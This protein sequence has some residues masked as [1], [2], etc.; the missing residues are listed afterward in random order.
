MPTPVLLS[1][2]VPP[3]QFNKLALI[4]TSGLDPVLGIFTGCFAYYLHETHPRTAPPPDK[5]LATL[6]QWKWA[7]FKRDREEK[8]NALE[9]EADASS[10]VAS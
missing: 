8:L 5:A 3:S 10:K 6:V 4:N 2:Y 1:R 7:K 9:R